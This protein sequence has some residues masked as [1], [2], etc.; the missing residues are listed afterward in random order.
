MSTLFIIEPSSEGGTPFGGDDLLE[1]A[2]YLEER[3]YSMKVTSREVVV[4]TGASAWL[5]KQG[6][7]LCLKDALLEE[8]VLQKTDDPSLLISTVKHHLTLL[9]AKDELLIIDPFFF[10]ESANADYLARLEAIFSDAISSVN[11]LRIVVGSERNL[12]LERDFLD[13]AQRVRPLITTAV[14]STDT[15]HDRFVIGDAAKGFFI[16]T[17]LNGIGRK[18]A[19]MDYMNDEDAKEIYK[20]FKQLP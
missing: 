16:G 19:I 4:S 3:G 5:L 18:Y 2:K 12:S 14:I 7:T 9:G 6:T 13:M 1:T 20:A 17:S 10:P 11:H 15:F 8:A